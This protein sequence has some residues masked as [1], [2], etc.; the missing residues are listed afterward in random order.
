MYNIY[1]SR[2]SS[3]A[4][5]WRPSSK[6]AKMRDPEGQATQPGTNQHLF[7]PAPAT[8]VI[9]RDDPPSALLATQ[10][11]AHQGTETPLDPKER[12]QEGKS[13]KVC[14]GNSE[15]VTSSAG[16]EFWATK[17]TENS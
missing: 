14:L 3:L 9:P 2:S 7:T 12:F 5:A 1:G 4:W 15:I 8:R 11:T 17:D 16:V 10:P 13:L 6:R